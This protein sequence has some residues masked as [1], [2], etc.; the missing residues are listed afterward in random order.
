ME[1]GW[2]E[3]APVSEDNKALVRRQEEELFSRG[4]LDAADEIYAP[5][6]VG[7]DPSNP[8]DVR[9]GSTVRSDPVQ[10]SARSGGPVGSKSIGTAF[11]LVKHSNALRLPTR[12][13]TLRSRV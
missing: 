13:T 11:V 1:A 9:G 5:D 12:W 4:N 3:G 7:H 6:Y 8:E 10:G 2:K